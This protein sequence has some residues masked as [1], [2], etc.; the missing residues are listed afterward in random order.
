MSFSLEAFCLE[1]SNTKGADEELMNRFFIITGGP[2][3]GK[4]VLIEELKRRGIFCVEEVARKIIQD[5]MALG[6]DALPGDNIRH[7]IEKML[8]RSIETYQEAIEKGHI[9]VFDRGVLDY[10]SYADRTHTQVSE[11]LYQAAFSLIYNKKVFITPI[12]EEIYC[13]DDERKHPFEEAIEVYHS[14]FKIYADH[15]YEVIELPKADVKARA[16]FIMFH[17]GI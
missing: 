3:S 10:I 6:G 7:R 4:T 12:W 13:H 17:I 8:T 9:T 2:G 16:D 11:E 15:G 14:C 1:G 5:E